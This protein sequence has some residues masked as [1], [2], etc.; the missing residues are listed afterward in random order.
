MTLMTGKLSS[1]VVDRQATI[2]AIPNLVH[3]HVRP[4]GS[5]AAAWLMAGSVDQPPLDSAESA[6]P[7]PPCWS[8][9]TTARQ[10]RC[11]GWHRFCHSSRAG[12]CSYRFYGSDHHSHRV[13]RRHLLVLLKAGHTL[14]SAFPPC[15]NI[16]LFWAFAYRR[17]WTSF[18][19]LRVT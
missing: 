8:T 15:A 5:H 16:L 14:I 13:V 18:P 3:K 4:S 10:C 7:C 12:T 19:V 17:H 9:T 11:D 6:E 1:S 2:S